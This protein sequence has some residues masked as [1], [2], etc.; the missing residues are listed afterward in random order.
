MG[1]ESIIFKLTVIAVI[2][3][4]LLLLFITITIL[5]FKENTV[6]NNTTIDIKVIYHNDTDELYSVFIYNN[7]PYKHIGKDLYNITPGK[8]ISNIPATIYKNEL[9][10]EL[11]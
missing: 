11:N 6:T 9:K 2:I 3:T 7:K 8:F 10:I 1:E 4:W 5:P